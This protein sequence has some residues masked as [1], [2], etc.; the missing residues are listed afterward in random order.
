MSRATPEQ[1]MALAQIDEASGVLINYGIH[2]IRKNPVKVGVWALGLLICLLFNGVAVTRE[3]QEKF[4]SS[5]KKVS[6]VEV[7]LD[8]A[9]LKMQQSEAD[10]RMNQ[11]W[12]WS[13]NTAPC[14]SYKR[15]FEADKASV[16]AMKKVRSDALSSAKSS[17]GLFSTYGVSETRWLFNDQF[18]RGKRFA[19]RQ[20]WWDALWMGIGAMGRDEGLINYLM[21][22]LMNVLINF[23][24]GVI[25]AL[26]GFLWNLWS[27]VI[28]YRANL[29]SA[30]IFF[31]LAAL[32]AASFAAAWLFGIYMAAAGTVYVG[33]RFLVANM[34]L[35]D[36]ARRQQR[37]RLD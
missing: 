3:Q 31:T 30:L 14:K 23:T 17:V 10:Y 26:I 32:A 35:Q 34:R 5:L 33:G 12:F 25:G 7:S 19:Q 13:C 36:D 20:S 8:D 6:N 16:D 18:T 9:I 27:L 29:L 24:L 37:G 28:E 15:D 1:R 11:G 21:R 22:V 2:A 4:N